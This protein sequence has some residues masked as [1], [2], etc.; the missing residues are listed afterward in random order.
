MGHDTCMEIYRRKGTDFQQT[1]EQKGDHGSLTWFV[2]QIDP[3]SLGI[4][5]AFQNQLVA[6]AFRSW[7][8]SSAERA[9]SGCVFALGQFWIEV[10]DKSV[11]F[12]WTWRR[13]TH[14]LGSGIRIMTKRC[15]KKF[16]VRNG[17]DNLMLG[18]GRKLS[19]CALNKA[20]LCHRHR[21]HYPSQLDEDG[22]LFTSRVT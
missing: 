20:K 2:L 1:A 17:L 14:D 16:T 5:S 13:E 3:G 15:D 7:H 6:Y 21:F 22:H 9:R 18:N 19:S 4:S 10:R 12:P 11:K 8:S